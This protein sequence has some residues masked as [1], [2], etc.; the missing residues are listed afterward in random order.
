MLNK[1][2]K[3]YNNV[4]YELLEKLGKGGFAETYKGYNKQR[5]QFVALKFFI[6]SSGMEFTKVQLER[7]YLEHNIFN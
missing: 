4:D 3:I 6:K 1:I 2:L 7:I 5:K